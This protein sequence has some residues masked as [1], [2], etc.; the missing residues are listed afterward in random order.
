MTEQ[1]TF[2]PSHLCP[3]FRDH[4]LLSRPMDLPPDFLTS[5][6]QQ[7]QPGPRLLSE[8]SLEHDRPREGGM[9]SEGSVPRRRTVSLFGPSDIVVTI[10]LPARDGAGKYNRAAEGELLGRREP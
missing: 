7:Y 9:V 8:A 4:S 5:A 2:F 1:S 3:Q 10:R 6:R